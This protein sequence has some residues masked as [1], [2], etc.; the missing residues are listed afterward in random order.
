MSKYIDLNE[1]TD[2]FKGIDATMTGGWVADTLE[3]LPTIEV[4]EEQLS[5]LKSRENSVENTTVSEDFTSI[6]R[7]NSKLEVSEDCISRAGALKA[8]NEAVDEL[9]KAEIEEFNLGDFT[10]CSFNT[11]QLKLIARKIEDAPSVVPSS[12][13]GEWQITEAYPH[14]VY[15]SECHK[16]FAQTHW[17]VWEDGSLPRNYCP[18]CGAKMRLE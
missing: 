4:S 2:L 11:T 5:K 10:E 9:V 15:C 3:A 7:A 18:N 8:Y 16:K 12:E 14:N 1:A 13:K 6:S 17:A